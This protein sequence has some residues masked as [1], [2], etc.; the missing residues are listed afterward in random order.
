MKDVLSHLIKH[1]EMCIE[2]TIQ[3]P[4]KTCGDVKLREYEEHA[5]QWNWWLKMEVEKFT[6]TISSGFLKWDGLSKLKGDEFDLRRTWKSRIFNV[7]VLFYK[8]Y[9]P[10]LR[11]IVFAFQGQEPRQRKL[12]SIELRFLFAMDSL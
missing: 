6:H 2:R 4:S 8:K 9:F 3:C 5:K 11:M 12:K 1:E 7:Q 10:I